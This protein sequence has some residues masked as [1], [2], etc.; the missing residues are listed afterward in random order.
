[1]LDQKVTNVGY[2][3]FEFLTSRL[4]I[5]AGQS[6]SAPSTAFSNESFL[7]AKRWLPLLHLF[8][9]QIEDSANLT[10]MSLSLHVR[11]SLQTVDPAPGRADRPEA[12]REQRLN[13][14]IGRLQPILLTKDML[15]SVTQGRPL[16]IQ[17]CKNT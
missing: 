1:M 13:G 11:R 10:K 2:K 4:R 14:E 6:S 16:M 8:H 12:E 15:P 3:D 7:E 9:R 5:F 17:A